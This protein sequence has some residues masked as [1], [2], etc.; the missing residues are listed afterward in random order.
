[1]CCAGSIAV[2]TVASLQRRHGRSARGSSLQAVTDSGAPASAEPEMAMQSAPDNLAAKKAA[3]D[4]PSDAMMADPMSLTV[5]QPMPFLPE[6]A[7]RRFVR[8]V[9]GDVGFDP[10]GL[11]GS[12]QQTFVSMYEAELKHGRIAML[13]GVGFAISEISHARLASALGLP[14]LMAKGGCAPTLLNGALLNPWLFG[15][16]CVIFGV[17][18][19]AEA[20]APRNNTGLP[21]YYG[22]DPLKL[23]DVEFSKLARSLLRGNVEWVAEAEIKHSRVAMLVVAYMAFH[24]FQTGTPTWPSL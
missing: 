16:L 11:A 5:L 15:S 1:M 23:S 21:G 10:L 24:E 14:N 7:Y 18:G 19:F 6:P 2:A 13:A 12:D 17:M 9:P 4:R 22:F 8:N 3:V 20:T